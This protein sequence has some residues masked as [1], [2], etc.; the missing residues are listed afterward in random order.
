MP[1]VESGRV[2][3]RWQ[4]PVTQF[5]APRWVSFMVMGSGLAHW[6]CLMNRESVFGRCAIPEALLL[7]RQTDAFPRQLKTELEVLNAARLFQIA[8]RRRRKGIGQLGDGPREIGQQ[9]FLI[10][11][12]RI[13]SIILVILG[14]TSCI[15]AF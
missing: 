13:S 4:E 7:C 3:T 10:H 14:V 15:L 8:P 5:F 6:R 12:L 11:T 2:C 1:P 9:N